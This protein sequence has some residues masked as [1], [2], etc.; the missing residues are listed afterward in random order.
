MGA[1]ILTSS[2]LYKHQ[3]L[4]V[5]LQ[6]IR[7]RPAF[8]RVGK[9]SENQHFFFM[10]KPLATKTFKNQEVLLKVTWFLWFPLIQIF[11][12]EPQSHQW[13][14]CFL[15]GLSPPPPQACSTDT[16]IKTSAML[17]ALAKIFSCLRLL[18]HNEMTSCGTLR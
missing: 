18:L 14:K 2:L 17:W 3:L 12:R 6:G 13:S 16:W 1:Y 8:L 15:W 4:W 7:V 5:L 11:W 10:I 9:G